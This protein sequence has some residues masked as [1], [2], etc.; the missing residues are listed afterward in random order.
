MTCA[1]PKAKPPI[2]EF[3]SLTYWYFAVWSRRNWENCL[4]DSEHNHFITFVK[5]AHFR[6]NHTVVLN[7]ISICCKSAKRIKLT[8]LRPIT[9][10]GGPG[11]PG[12]PGGPLHTGKLL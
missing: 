3:H 6:I 12:G 1:T 11:D 5:I 4:Q 10:P 9:R 7:L 8:P 2:G